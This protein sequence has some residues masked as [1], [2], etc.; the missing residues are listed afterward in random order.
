M[1]KSE[2]HADIHFVEEIIKEAFEIIIIPVRGNYWI[3]IIIQ[4][5]NL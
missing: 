4:P 1:Y 5:A 3:V 2:M